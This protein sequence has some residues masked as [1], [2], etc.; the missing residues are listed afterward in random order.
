MKVWNGNPDNV[1]K[2]RAVF[3]EQAKLC[4]EASLGKLP[5]E[6]KLLCAQSYDDSIQL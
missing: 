3:L 5:F 1:A 2:A 4:S 6:K